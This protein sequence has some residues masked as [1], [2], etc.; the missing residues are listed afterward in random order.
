MDTYQPHVHWV[1]QVLNLVGCVAIFLFYRTMALNT[2]YPATVDLLISILL[3]EYCR[4][5]NEGRRIA[6]RQAA[7]HPK[8]KEDVEKHALT[9]SAQREA[10]SSEAIAAVV[11]WREDPALWTRCLESY[12]KA[13]G[14]KFLLAGIDGHDPDDMEMVDIF[15]KVYPTQSCVV[16]VDEPLGEIANA[17]RAS[18]KMSRRKLG[19]AIDENGINAIAMEQCKQVAR[20]VLEQQLGG[21]S[22][23]GPEGMKQL[24]V[25]QRH[26]HK[27][28]IMFTVL[29]FSIV[30]AD[31][32]GVE[33]VW[34]SDSDTIVLPESLDGTISTVAGDHTIGGASSGLVVHNAAD[35]VVTK[36]AST[37]YW[38]ELY[39]TRSMPGS[40][41]VS[42]CQSG[43]SAVFR[44]SA[45]SPILIRWYNQR[46]FGKKMIVNEDRH[47][48]TLLLLNGWHVIYAGDIMTETESPVTLVRWIRQQVR[49]ARAQ[50]IESLLLPRVYAKS[51]PFL[52]MSALRRELAHLVVF[53]QCLLY[54][55][56]EHNL[57]YFNMPDFGLRIIGIALY[58]FLRNPDRQ[59][60]AAVVWMIP[61]LLFYNVPLPAVQAWSLV[62][63]T[64]DTWGNCMRSS[65]ERA[66]KESTRKKWF[67]SG[68]FVIWMGVVGAMLAKWVST[69]MALMP[70]QMLVVMLSA[71]SLS[72]FIFWRITIQSN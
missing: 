39:L 33:F 40:M 29:V 14:C 56:T 59:S 41:A 72:T 10:A 31:M 22:L 4:F 71:A 52:F 9:A 55:F 7:W 32:L 43:P 65:T 36:L 63:L 51:H 45:I 8:D 25:Y 66:K 38:C 26:M 37:I 34:S 11:G 27:K 18:E 28:G 54:L 5:N 49:W 70:G 30:L 48:T 58:N 35:T 13:V 60:T 2:Y 12:K 69:R 23:S 6:F 57:L 67:E 24:L 20:R 64:A 1:R 16:Y 17:V 68:F 61:G 50:H 62:T 19:D 53:V 46:V 3:A 15:K 42:D 47:L 21:R 44:L